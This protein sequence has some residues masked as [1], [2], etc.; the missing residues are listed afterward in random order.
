MALLRVAKGIY[1]PNL[2]GIFFVHKIY[3]IDH[4]AFGFELEVISLVITS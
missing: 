2:P 1:Q 4:T 3:L